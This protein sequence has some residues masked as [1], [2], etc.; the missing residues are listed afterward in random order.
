LIKR[1]RS[2]SIRVS[3]QSEIIP[4]WTESINEVNA[5]IH[6]NIIQTDTIC[7]WYFHRLSFNFMN[8]LE[9]TISHAV[10]L[11]KASCSVE[12]SKR[13]REACLAYLMW[14]CK[15]RVDI[16]LFSDF[17]YV[18]ALVVG[19]LVHFDDQIRCE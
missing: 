19:N 13:K 6:G 3:L 16:D 11:G 18:H 8:D 10:E 9:I 7:I 15:R 12:H 1:I 5:K 17:L 4:N 2:N 14:S